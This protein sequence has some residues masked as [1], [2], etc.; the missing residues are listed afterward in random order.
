MSSK[1]VAKRLSN[2]KIQENVDIPFDSSL[3]RHKESRI[4]FYKYLGLEQLPSLLK[5]EGIMKQ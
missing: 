1:V 3:I 4:L 5:N 2:F